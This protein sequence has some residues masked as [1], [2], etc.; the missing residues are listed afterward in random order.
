MGWMC[1]E[2]YGIMSVNVD[3]DDHAVDEVC[4]FSVRAGIACDSNLGMDGHTPLYYI[5]TWLRSSIDAFSGN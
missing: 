2:K 1:E 3:A 5:D 4:M